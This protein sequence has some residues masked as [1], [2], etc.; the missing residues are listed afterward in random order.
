MCPPISFTRNWHQIHLNCQKF[1]HWTIITAISWPLP[2]IFT[3]A[4]WDWHTAWLFLYWYYFFLLLHIHN[5]PQLAYVVSIYLFLYYRNDMHHYNKPAII[6]MYKI[7]IFKK[8]YMIHMQ[9]TV[10]A[11]TKRKIRQVRTN[12]NDN[13][14]AC[15]IQLR[16]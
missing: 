2:T 7:L 11:C 9:N 5:T 10:S 14:P 1:C 15:S 16:K 12:I 6:D 13:I 3:L 4:F 8:M